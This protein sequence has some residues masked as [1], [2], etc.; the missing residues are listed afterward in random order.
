MADPSTERLPKTFRGGGYEVTVNSDR[1]I[2]VRSGDWLSKYSAAIYGN[3]DHVGE[4]YRKSGGQWIDIVNKDAITAGETLYWLPKGKPAGGAPGINPP[5][6]GAPGVIVPDTDDSL[7]SENA[8]KFLKW[9][10]DRFIYTDWRVDG[11]SGGDL[12][13]SIVT[14][15]YANLVL[16]QISTQQKSRFHALA[17]GMSLGFPTEGF[18]FG[19]SFSLPVPPFKGYGAILKFAW[20]RELKLED[21]RW[22]IVVLEFGGSAIA[23]ASFS[24]VV[25]G[26]HFPVLLIEAVF[27]YFRDGDL[28]AM[29]TKFRGAMPKGVIFLA[30]GLIGVPG[31]SVAGRAGV[32]YDPF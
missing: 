14:V 30:G 7:K 24:L 9:I 22:G 10:Y 2:Q 13:F 1:S 11:S 28:N 31:I 19:G 20:V 17:V 5:V 32:M 16:E 8:A 6:G 27:Q 12:S 21:F 23:G 18:T 15:Q 29:E 25:F 3:F 26:L 4:F